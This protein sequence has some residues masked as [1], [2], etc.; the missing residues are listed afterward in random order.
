[1]FAEF[2]ELANEFVG[3]KTA[4]ME[5]FFI[6]EDRQY[7]AA[8]SKQA[9]FIGKGDRFS[10]NKDT[11]KE[12]VEEHCSRISGKPQKEYPKPE[13]TKEEQKNEEGVKSEL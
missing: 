13:E 1:M 9:S 12:F 6:R 3:Q 5:I 2:N 10:I 7:E 8:F 4:N 11:F